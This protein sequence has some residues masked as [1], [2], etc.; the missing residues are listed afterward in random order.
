MPAIGPGPFDP[1]GRGSVARPEVR[2]C[3]TPGLDVLGC[4]LSAC[5]KPI[6][7]RLSK[8]QEPQVDERARRPRQSMPAW[9]PGAARCMKVGNIQ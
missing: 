2:S 4:G 3:T 9:S 6:D 1:R 5:G 8:W 7:K